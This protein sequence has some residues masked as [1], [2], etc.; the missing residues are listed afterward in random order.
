M[1]VP[2]V[3]WS[4]CRL[5]D[6]HSILKRIVNQAAPARANSRVWLS[7]LIGGPIAGG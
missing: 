1:D 3:T 7:D 5:K 6:H 2:R 4:V